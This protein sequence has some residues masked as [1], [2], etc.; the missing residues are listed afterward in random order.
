[1]YGPLVDDGQEPFETKFRFAHRSV[2]VSCAL[3]FDVAV[4]EAAHVALELVNDAHSVE[5]YD[6]LSS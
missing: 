4:V 1:M 6:C 2:P 3:L 5:D